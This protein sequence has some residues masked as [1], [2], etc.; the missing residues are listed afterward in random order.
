MDA[1]AARILSNYTSEYTI[2]YALWDE[3]ELGLLGSRFYAT[4][5]KL[6][7]ENVMGVINI[8]MIGWDSNDDD[9]VLVV[10]TDIANSIELSNR[11]IE[12]NE[13]YQIG[14]APKTTMM[15][16]SD[17]LTFWQNGFGAV[18]IIEYHGKDFN[19]YYHSPEDKIEHFNLNYFYKCSKLAIGVLAALVETKGKKDAS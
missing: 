14:L 13:S 9:T 16:G 15:G 5:A 3:E 6:F 12:T 2:M 8:D 18:T 10:T 11:V 1:E 17:H 4:N 19:N 7:N